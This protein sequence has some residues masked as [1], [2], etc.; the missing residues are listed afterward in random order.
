[1]RMKHYVY[2]ITNTVN[3]KIY[4]GKH[5]S[6]D[7][8]DG[9]FG[10]GTLLKQA[11]KKYGRP[12]F[13]KIMLE[14][15][16]SAEGA[17]D[18]EIRLIAEH[19]SQERDIGYNMTSGGDGM[20]NL[21][22]ESHAKMVKKR[23]GVKASAETRA[24]MS[25]TRKGRIPSDAHRAAL[26]KAGKAR[27]ALGIHVDVS[28]ETRKKLSQ[29]NKGSRN[30]AAKLNEE[31]VLEIKRLLRD[32][33][34]HYEIAKMFGVSHITVYFI[35]NERLWSH[36]KLNDDVIVLEQCQTLET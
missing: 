4:I 15:H 33:I 36:V 34:S 11:I 9:Y 10:S 16:D 35:K 30:P 1:M 31:K 3:G 19:R 18:A 12:A 24:K 32:G 5:S 20:R 27:A 2:K 29:S 17:L 22:P 25:A 28:A 26:S 6:E 23:T 13:V 7:F 14:E 8:D 21:S